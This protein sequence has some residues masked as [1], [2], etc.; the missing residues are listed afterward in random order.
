MDVHGSDA[1]ALVGLDEFVVTSGWLADGQWTLWIER[2]PVEPVGCEGCGTRAWRHDH[3]RHV[4]RDLPIS[5]VPVRLVWRKQLWRCPDPDCL[6]RCFVDVSHEIDQRAVLTERDRTYIAR[7]VGPGQASVSALAD[8]FAVSWWAAMDAVRDHA[9]ARTDHVT[10]L[11]APRAIGLDETSFLAA[12]PTSPTQ[13]VTHVVNLD[14]GATID[15][16]EGRSKPAVVAW[17]QSKPKAWRDGIEHVVIDPH[18]PYA[19]AVREWLPQ[20]RIVV[21]HFHIIRLANQALDEVRRRVQQDTLDH[22]GHRDD[23]LYRIRRRLLCAHDK[24]APGAFDRVLSWLAQGDPDGEVSAAYLAKELLR[25][26][27]DAAD[28]MHARRQLVVFYQ[29]VA[30]AEIPE[31]TRLATTISQWESELLRWHLTGLSNGPVEGT[32]LVVKNTKRCGYGFRNFNN[33]RHRVLLRCGHRWQPVTTP[34]LHPAPTA[35]A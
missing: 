15:V 24:L 5:G 17:L 26:V 3:R 25:Q 33:Y 14:S 6:V 20:A 34:P 10:A 11:G 21:D 19:A 8:E 29:H 4:V 7:R 28:A 23:P 18:Q 32:N 27:Y 9:A 16:L 1:S 13:F 30:D 2:Q 31:L 12:T 35:V 22:R